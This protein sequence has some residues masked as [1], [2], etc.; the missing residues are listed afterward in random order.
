[1]GETSSRCKLRVRWNWYPLGREQTWFLGVLSSAISR[2]RLRFRS[3]IR[4]PDLCVLP[5]C[6]SEDADLRGSFQVVNLICCGEVYAKVSLGY[7]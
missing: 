5:P 2:V 1:M 6:I 3:P 4:L 7:W